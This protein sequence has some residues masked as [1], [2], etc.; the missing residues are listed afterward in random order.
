[1]GA[2]LSYAA[3]ALARLNP[4][5]AIWVLLAVIGVAFT[6]MQ[7]GVT[8]ADER[9][10]LLSGIEDEDLAI[11]SRAAVRNA[12]GRLCIKLL[13]L[14]VGVQSAALE[15][16]APIPHFG[17]F[18]AL[19]FIVALLI[20]DYLSYADQRERHDLNETLTRRRIEKMAIADVA[21]LTAKTHAETLAAIKENTEITRRADEHATAAYSVANHI[22]EKIAA[23]NAN[24]ARLVEVHTAQGETH[25]TQL[26]AMSA[27]EEDTNVRVQDVQEKADQLT[28]TGRDGTTP[29]PGEAQ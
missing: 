7:F 10:R 22:N 23:G 14:L 29:P 4:Y 12:M 21:A 1:M 20:M 15:L 26:D 6:L 2:P 16:G 24:V 11:A 19:E 13:F 5:V 17:D 8:R 27:T 3:A 25:A 18:F 28:R 9:N